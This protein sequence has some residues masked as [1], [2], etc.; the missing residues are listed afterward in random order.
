MDQIYPLIILRFINTTMQQKN[1]ASKHTK[2]NA[3]KCYLKYL[4]T[5]GLT[6]T[7]HSTS[8]PKVNY[9]SQ[10][11]LPSSFSR[12]EVK[13]LLESIDRGNP[14][15]RRDYAILLLASKRGLRASDIAGLKFE[16]IHWEQ[17]LISFP[18]LKTKKVLTIP[19]LPEIGN[20]IIDYLKNG[21]P[22]SNEPYCFLQLISPYKPINGGT[23]GNVTRYHLDIAEINYANRK[24]GPHALRHSLAGNLLQEKIP[25][26]IISEVLGHVNSESSLIYLRVDLTSLRQCALDVP[27]VDEVFYKRKKGGNHHA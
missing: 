25:I 17:N 9:K 20:A 13:L 18:Q 24:H 22:I 21:R 19:L 23:V 26:P 12:D 14:K 6:T 5:R 3:I 16:H 10:A 2:L 8:V 4:Y 7:D 11:R 1:L 15:G 27:P